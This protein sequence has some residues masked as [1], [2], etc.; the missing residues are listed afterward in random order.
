MQKQE[1]K[2]KGLEQPANLKDRDHLILFYR[3]IC[4]GKD[5]LSSCNPMMAAIIHKEA[6]TYSYLTPEWYGHY[7]DYKASL[8]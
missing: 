7:L 8:D 3:L 2:Q 4:N 5:P 1:P 6:L